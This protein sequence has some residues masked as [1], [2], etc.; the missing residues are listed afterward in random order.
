[1]SDYVYGPPTD[2][3]PFKLAMGLRTLDPAQWLEGGPD[4]L[5]QL[6]ERRELIAQQRDLIYGT[7]PG[8]TAEINFFVEAI[9]PQLRRVSRRRL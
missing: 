4:L 9:R 7:I 5:D 6:R 1:V 3:K 8:H 2:G